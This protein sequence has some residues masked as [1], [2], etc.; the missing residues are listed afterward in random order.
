MKHKNK[1]IQCENLNLWFNSKKNIKGNFEGEDLKFVSMYF[2]EENFNIQFS[3]VKILDE[4]IKKLS[5][6]DLKSTF[7]Q[8]IEFFAYYENIQ[9]KYEFL[10]KL[11][12]MIGELKS[13]F[14]NCN[15]HEELHPLLE[16][17]FK[18]DFF[19]KNFSINQKL[20]ILRRNF[21]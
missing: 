14:L 21:W 9:I 6:E 3:G 5:F 16:I 1:K 13:K 10:S 12:L 18:I 2:T 19:I 4:I 8:K 17:F 20:Y 11:G 15:S 7:I